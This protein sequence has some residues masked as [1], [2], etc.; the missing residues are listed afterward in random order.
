MTFDYPKVGVK[1]DEGTGEWNESPFPKTPKGF[2]GGAIFGVAKKAGL[3]EQTVYNCLVY[4]RVAA[5]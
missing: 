3:I 2:S 5:H 4:N 1:Y